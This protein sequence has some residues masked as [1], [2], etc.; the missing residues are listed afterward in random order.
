M[1]VGAIGDHTYTHPAL[2]ALSPAQITWQLKAAAQK[3]YAQSGARVELFRPP[4]ELHNR[5]VDRIAQHLGLLQILW[6]VDSQDSLGAE[7]AQII[8]NVETGLHPGAIIAMHDNRG[9]TI[10]ALTALLPE[11][12][13]RHL[14]AVTIPEL[15]ASDP[16]SDQQLRRGL[17]GCE[18]YGEPRSPGGE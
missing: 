4:Y 14:R 18:S 17:E 8:R 11:L 16:P 5:T 1:R 2:V 10:R 7:Y 13:R 9:Q 15:L 6:S 3:I 12:H